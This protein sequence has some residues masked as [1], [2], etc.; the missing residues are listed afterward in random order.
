MVAKTIRDEFH[1]HLSP[2]LADKIFSD[3]KLRKSALKSARARVP[4]TMLA[5][6]LRGLSA[7]SERFP[8]AAVVELLN[9]FFALVTEVAFEYD[10]AIFPTGADSLMVG[11]GVPV[12][13][14]DRTERAFLAARAMLEKFTALA[15]RWDAKYF[16]EAGLGIGINAGD[17]FVGNLGAPA[18]RNFTL[19]GDSVNMAYRLGRRARAGELVLSESVKYVL[20]NRGIDVKTTRLPTINLASGHPMD[21]FCVP[22][23]RRID[24]RTH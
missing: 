11:F 15:E 20:D 18:Q 10:G 16:T 24:F 13:Q 23:G 21:I 6:D 7:I 1:R 12:E 19:I 14:L 22:A 9:Q 17:V 4:G 5:A 8:P 3:P 2:Q